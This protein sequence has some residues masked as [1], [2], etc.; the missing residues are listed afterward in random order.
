MSSSC[1][2]SM[3]LKH[4][5]QRTQRDTKVYQSS[6]WSF[7]K[8]MQA[9]PKQHL[10]LPQG[11]PS[12]VPSSC[13]KGIKLFPLCPHRAR[14]VS[15]SSFV[16][17]VVMFLTPIEVMIFFLIRPTSLSALVLYEV[18]G[19]VWCAQLRCAPYE[20]PNH[21]WISRWNS[22]RSPMQIPKP[23]AVWTPAPSGSTN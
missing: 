23:R 17:F 11:N 1:P 14:R 16:T 9:P 6:K 22:Y 18:A 15:C 7:H 4:K 3:E 13:L 21:S 19:S 8:L 12:F 10:K 20:T 5:P 2:N